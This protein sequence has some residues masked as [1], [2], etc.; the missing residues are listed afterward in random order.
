MKQMTRNRWRIESWQGKILLDDIILT[1]AY[2]AEMF[3]KAYISSF[4]SWGYILITKDK[5]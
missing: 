3:I 4:P 5:K 2:D 1:T